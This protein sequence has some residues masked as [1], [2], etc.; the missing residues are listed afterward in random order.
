MAAHGFIRSTLAKG[1]HDCRALDNWSISASR[2]L[3]RCLSLLARVLAKKPG[4]YAP[5]G[6]M[7]CCRSGALIPG[8]YDKNVT[9]V[10]A[11]D[12][13]HLVRHNPLNPGGLAWMVANIPGGD[14][15]TRL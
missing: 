9:S 2:S 11:A 7:A 1:I 5:L 12:L 13:L 15:K 14:A 10:L 3:F 6:G 8:V 4:V